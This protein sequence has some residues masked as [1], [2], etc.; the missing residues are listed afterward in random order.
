MNPL[1]TLF[2]FLL[3]TVTKNSASSADNP[4]NICIKIVSLFLLDSVLSPPFVKRYNLFASLDNRVWSVPSGAS[5][6]SYGTSPVGNNHSTLGSNAPFSTCL[7]GTVSWSFNTL[8][9]LGLSL[10]LFTFIAISLI[11]GGSALPASAA[12]LMPPLVDNAGCD[13]VCSSSPS[14][15]AIEPSGFLL[16]ITILFSLTVLSKLKFV[17][18][19]D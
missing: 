16:I 14:R 6:A 15:L 1:Y 19:F 12:A 9:F 10:A 18:N 5:F 3:I 8:S 17:Y 7:K 13:C 2:T 4:S 11:N